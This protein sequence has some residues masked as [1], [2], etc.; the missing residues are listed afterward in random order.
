MKPTFIIAIVIVAMIGVMIPSGF[1]TSGEIF[2]EKNEFK[3]YGDGSLVIFSVTGEI[4]DYT[5]RPELEIVQ[6]DLVIQSVK[7]SIQ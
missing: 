5:H 4:M 3:L 2:L 7:L 6:N 1:S